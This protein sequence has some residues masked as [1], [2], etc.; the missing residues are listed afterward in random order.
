MRRARLAAALAGLVAAAVAAPA[1]AASAGAR[2]AGHP[3]ILRLSGVLRLASGSCAGGTPSGSYLSVTFGTRAIDNPASDCE[4]GAVTLLS[5]GREGLSTTS[6]SPASEDGFDGRG[7][8]VAQSITRPVAFGKHL[9]GLVSSAQDLQDAPTGPG[10]FSLPHIYVTGDK[11]LADVRSVQVLYG[12]QADTTCA[13]GAGA[14]CWLIG[15]ERA[16]GTY[17]AATRHITLSWFSGQ[18]FV[19]QSAGTAVHLSGTF[20]GAEPKPVSTHGV[21][22]LGTSSF[23]AASPPPAVVAAIRH[24]SPPPA[25]AAKR[26]AVAASGPASERSAL[27]GGEDSPLWRVLG[28]PLALAVATLLIGVDGLLLAGAVGRRR[29]R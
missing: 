5:P 29:T 26:R 2:S 6:F 15:A 11:V 1:A 9:L 12:G 3:G 28:S 7:N 19:P 25:R 16:T 27:T 24:S 8:A 18:S 10:L 21:V 13:S 4:G 20:V 23:S 17:D 14:G 22:E